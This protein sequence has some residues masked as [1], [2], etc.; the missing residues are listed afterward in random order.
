MVT[1]VEVVEQWCQV[2]AALDVVN[3]FDILCNALHEYIHSIVGVSESDDITGVSES[4]DITGIDS[5]ALV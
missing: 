2:I 1:F 4:D 3:E 5:V